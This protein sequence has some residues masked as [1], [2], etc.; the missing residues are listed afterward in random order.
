MTAEIRL[1]DWRT[2]LADVG[3]VD[4]VITDPPYSAR[5]H[6]GALSSTGEVG[7]TDYACWTPE[8]AIAF[9]DHW[10]PRVRS[11]IVILT[12]DVLGPV[13][14]DRLQDLGRYGFPLLPILQHGHRKMC[15]GPAP[16]GCFAVVSRPREA[17]FVAFSDEGGWGA[18]PGHYRA[19][20][21]HGEIMG[22][23]P[24]PLMQ[25]FVRDYSR[26]GDLVCDPFVGSG[27]TA[28]AALSEGR[29]FVGSEQKREHYDIATRR[30]AKGYTVDMFAG[31]VS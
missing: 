13:M 4:C 9:C 14:R 31:G 18:L 22:A 29:R 16:P 20:R 19:G 10:T 17:R 7:V 2:A 8:D 11:W 25:Q 6:A 27:T 26:P 12:D 3:E 23:K 24:L 21:E 28:L 5:T 1:G 30:L 15:D